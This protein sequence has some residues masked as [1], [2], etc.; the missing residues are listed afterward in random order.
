MERNVR[1][2]SMPILLGEQTIVHFQKSAVK[3]LSLD[4]IQKAEDEEH[5]TTQGSIFIIYFGAVQKGM[6]VGM[7]EL[8]TSIYK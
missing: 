6:F 2:S 3:F 8:F 1:Y 7:M 4:S 5:W